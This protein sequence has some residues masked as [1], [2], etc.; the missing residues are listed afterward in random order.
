MTL[1]FN[2]KLAI[3]L[4]LS[5]PHFMLMTL[6]TVVPVSSACIQADCTLCVKFYAIII[7]SLLN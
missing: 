5:Q 4:M 6:C 1:V 3:R 7:T 2:V